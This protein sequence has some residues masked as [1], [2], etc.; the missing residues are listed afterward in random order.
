MVER[1]NDLISIE[2]DIVDD[3]NSLILGAVWTKKNEECP[4][5]LDRILS[6]PKVLKSSNKSLITLSLSLFMADYYGEGTWNEV[7][8]DENKESRQ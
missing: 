2:L 7:Q 3:G 4:I 8:Q 1:K 5:N 6:D